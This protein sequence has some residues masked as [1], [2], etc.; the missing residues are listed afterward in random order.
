MSTCQE[1]EC[2]FRRPNSYSFFSP[3]RY[4]FCGLVSALQYPCCYL[5]RPVSFAFY[6]Y[7]NIKY[8]ALLVPSIVLNYWAAV[9]ITALS[10]PYKRIAAAIAVAGNLGVLLFFKYTGFLI[11]NLNNLL[12]APILVP[13]IVLPLGV[14]FITFQKI[15]Y[16]VD[17]YRGR[18]R[19]QGFLRFALFVSFFPQLIAGPIAHHAEFLPQVT[20]RLGLFAQNVAV[21]LS[22]FAIGLFKKVMIADGVA[23]IADAAFAASAGGVPLSPLSAWAGALAYTTQLYFDFSGYS[24]MACGLALLLDRL[25]INFFTPY[26]STSIIEFWHRWHRTLSRFLR[27]Y[28]YIPLGGNRKGPAR[29]YVN[30]MVTMTLGGLWHGAGWT[31]VVWGAYHGMLLLVNHAWRGLTVAWARQSN[32]ATG[33]LAIALTFIGVVIG[34]V[35]FKA[36]TIATAGMMLSSM[37][38]FNAAP[39]AIAP[40]PDAAQSIKLIAAMGCIWLLP[41]TYQVFARYRAA[42]GEVAEPRW[43][44]MQWRPSLWWAVATA[45]CLAVTL[46][47]RRATLSFLYFQF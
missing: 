12:D 24:D 28:L 6:G 39:P 27:D 36:D 46:L 45:S 16:I 3:L 19:D 32:P 1:G 44:W 41:N 9:V 35:V 43:R 11:T 21:G 22:V 17:V 2:Y 8:L 23:E 42:L 33:A 7:W 30:L 34:W 25:P 5:A 4:R 18:A 15:T 13:A 14:S 47:P 38:G 26:K 20:G 31:F 40:T 29:R 10:E 37:T